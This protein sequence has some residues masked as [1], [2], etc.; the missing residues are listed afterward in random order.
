MPF[1]FWFRPDPPLGCTPL[2]HTSG[3]DATGRIDHV[4]RKSFV[5]DPFP[6]PPSTF[7]MHPSVLSAICQG[8]EPPA[9]KP[10]IKPFQFAIE[11]LGVRSEFHRVP[12]G[13]DAIPNRMNRRRIRCRL[14]NR[15][16]VDLQEQ[17]AT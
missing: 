15:T 12:A 8:L 3:G 11:R 5:P 1:P 6:R 2:L 13:A 7:R 14:S 10:G 4:I 17:I 9:V 16:L